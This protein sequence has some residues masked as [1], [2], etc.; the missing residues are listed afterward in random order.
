[1]QHVG[2]YELVMG[3]KSVHEIIIMMMG[4]LQVLM[5]TVPY[6]TFPQMVCLCPPSQQMCAICWGIDHICALTT[7]ACWCHSRALM[8]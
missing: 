3:L 5:K 6:Y 4:T 7:C 8:W 1:M 2:R